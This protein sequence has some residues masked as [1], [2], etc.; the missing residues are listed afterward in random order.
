MGNYISCDSTN[1]ESNVMKVIKLYGNVQEFERPMKAAELMLD[2]P[3]HFVCHSTA[4]QTGRRILALSADEELELGN[5]YFLLPMQKLH[6]S[7]S[8]SE[9]ASLASLTLKADPAFQRSTSNYKS[10][11]RILPKLG[12]LC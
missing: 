11:T 10:L 9:I 3:Q 4:V 5:L 2:N 1:V 6:S 8:P 7:P 12:D